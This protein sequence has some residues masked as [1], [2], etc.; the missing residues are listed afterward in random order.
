MISTLAALALLMPGAVEVDVEGVARTPGRDDPLAA[1][2]RIEIH[3]GGMPFAFSELRV[4]TRDKP[5]DPHELLLVTDTPERHVV[6]RLAH[7][8]ATAK[9]SAA[10]VLQ[11]T[12]V[13][14]PDAPLLI[15][16]PAD[17]TWLRL[18]SRRKLSKQVTLSLV[19]RDSGDA[20]DVKI[21]AQKRPLGENPIHEAGTE[22]ARWAEGLPAL[23]AS[24]GPNEWEVAPGAWRLESDLVVPRGA[25]LRLRPG[26]TLL[27]DP[28]HS[29]V[30]YGR[31]SFEGRADAPITLKN[32]GIGCWGVV[33]LSGDGANGSRFSHVRFVHASQGFA[34]ATDLNGALTVIDANATVEDCRFE[35]LIG[36]DALHVERSHVEIKRTAFVRLVSDGIDLVNGEAR[37]EDALFEDI[38]D[39]AVDAGHGSR[40]TLKGVLVRRAAG[41]AAS[42]GQGS[43]VK[44]ADSVFLDSVRGI[45]SFD[46]AD[47]FAETTLIA[48]SKRSS[49][50]VTGYGDAKPGRARLER[51]LLWQNEGSNADIEAGRVVLDRTRSDVAIDLAHYAPVNAPDGASVGPP[52]IPSPP[53]ELAA[54]AAGSA[55]PGILTSG[56]VA[57]VA[58]VEKPQR[59]P[60][61]YLAAAAAAALAL[62]LVFEARRKS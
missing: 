1:I 32:G 58:K 7:V 26:T 48:F 47:V 17:G 50:Q 22:P 38:G 54:E 41:K 5:G 62:L 29:I 18:A 60:W 19:K 6:G 14:I 46:D 25:T 27:F 40:A 33:A 42:S 23:H 59:L 12:P 2:L 30:S 43:Q 3:P 13:A 28:G 57:T 10:Y 49:V 9:V 52:R 31:L 53:A 55:A 8:P 35:D 24:D 11:G 44:I 16:A 4:E 21:K 56:A 36:E 61:L 45:S 20:V 39:D 51:C 37:I 15:A 34:G